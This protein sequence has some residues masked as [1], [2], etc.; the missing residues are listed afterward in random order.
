MDSALKHTMRFSTLPG[1]GE[2]DAA[3]SPETNAPGPVNRDGV[4]APHSSFTSSTSS[5][6]P[7][8][9]LVKALKQEAADD[10][11]SR[12]VL[13]LQDCETHRLEAPNPGGATP[14]GGVNDEAKPGVE[15][16]DASSGGNAV[17]AEAAAAEAGEA[18]D[19]VM[20]PCTA[21]C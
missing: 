11:R 8:A 5:A 14:G 19:A 21:P 7:S 10:A 1:G 17:A 18:A 6:T 4:L 20:I 12:K 9:S 3:P 13:T 16:F 15:G 2:G